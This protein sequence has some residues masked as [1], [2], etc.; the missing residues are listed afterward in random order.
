MAVCA[1]LAL[2]A[3]ATGCT[4][5]ASPPVPTSSTT[6][7]SAVSSPAPT[8]SPTSTVSTPPA[9]PDAMTSPTADGAAAAATYFMAVYSYMYATADVAAWE[10]LSSPTCDFC[11]GRRD[12]ATRM[13]GS[14]AR[15]EGEPVAVLTS[16]GVEIDPDR[17]FSATLS[18]DEPPSEEVA[19]DGTVVSSSAGG[20]YELYFA[21]SWDGDW[22]VEA[23]DV[24]RTDG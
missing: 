9:R 4:D 2:G 6:P 8:A 11:I 24:S 21:L 22:T 19:E 10:Q 5:P 13:A 23:V 12:D 17:W 20:T 7:S 3:L 18:I 14:G 1:G 16:S 15:T